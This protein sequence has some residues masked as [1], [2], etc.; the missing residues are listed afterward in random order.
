MAAGARW[1]WPLVSWVLTLRTL[2]LIGNL[3]SHLICSYTFPTETNSALW[4]CRATR[5]SVTPQVGGGGRG[6]LQCNN[7][8]WITV[9]LSEGQRRTARPF[10]T[11]SYAEFTDSVYLWYEAPDARRS[12]TAGPQP[13][14]YIIHSQASGAR[15]SSPFSFQLQ[16]RMIKYRWGHDIGCSANQWQWMFPIN[17]EGWL[18]Y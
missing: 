16:P 5:V 15:E 11:G 1:G 14:T 3:C 12:W 4:P 2:D 6:D 7:S 13:F 10:T 17:Y 8:E 9:N 18:Y